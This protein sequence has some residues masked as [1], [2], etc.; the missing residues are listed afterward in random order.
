VANQLK[1]A[2]IGVYECHLD[3]SFVLKGRWIKGY[4]GLFRD[5]LL[6]SMIIPDLKEA[7]RAGQNFEFPVLVVS[8]SLGKGASPKPFPIPVPKNKLTVKSAG[9]LNK[10]RRMVGVPVRRKKIPATEIQ[11]A[12]IDA[13]GQIFKVEGSNLKSS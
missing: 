5:A 6:D 7:K 8:Y 3:G 2:R 10:L 12:V 13:Q 9:G 11:E 1:S 4:Y